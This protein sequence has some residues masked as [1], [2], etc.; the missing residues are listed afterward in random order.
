MIDESSDPAIGNALKFQAHV[1]AVLKMYGA[2]VKPI[3]RTP[4]ELREAAAAYHRY[5]DA[6]DE[7]PVDYNVA[8]WRRVV[9]DMLA[10]MLGLDGFDFDR[11]LESFAELMALG[12]DPAF[13]FEDAAHHLAQAQ[14]NTQ[15]PG[16]IRGKRTGRPRRWSP[17]QL[18]QL[19]LDREAGKAIDDRQRLH[20]AQDPELNPLAPYVLGQHDDKVL[21][22]AVRDTVRIVGQRVRKRNS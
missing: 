4:E 22:E 17:V 5:L 19:L 8:A 3:A 11:M 14:V 16:L 6:G 20:D 15:Y 1:D 9:R 21:C 13:R 7:V 18:T 10:D 12:E 2:P